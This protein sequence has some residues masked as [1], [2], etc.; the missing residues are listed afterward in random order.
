M[1]SF[2]MKGVSCIS[3]LLYIKMLILIKYNIRHFFYRAC[4]LVCFEFNKIG[5]LRF[6][7]EKHFLIFFRDIYIK[8]K[9]DRFISIIL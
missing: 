8:N 7:C 2:W 6:W 1:R 9:T 4:L 3:T 5:T